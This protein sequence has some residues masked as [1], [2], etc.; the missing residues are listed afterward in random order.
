VRLAFREF[1]EE[2][3]LASARVV[4]K[5]LIESGFE[6]RYPELDG[7]LRAICEVR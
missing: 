4:P 7:A 2:G 5:K 6:F 3:L 1:A